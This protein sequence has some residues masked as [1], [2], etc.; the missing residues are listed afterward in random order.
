MRKMQ[1]KKLSL[2]TKSNFNKPVPIL[3]RS[4]YKEVRVKQLFQHLLTGR[5]ICELGEIFF[6]KLFTQLHKFHWNVK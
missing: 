5:A 2:S 1:I 3:L 4:A 6:Q